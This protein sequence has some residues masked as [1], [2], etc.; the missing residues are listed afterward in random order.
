MRVTLKTAV[1]VRVMSEG[2]SEY[3]S[4]CDSLQD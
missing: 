1:S 4:E 3:S 2:H